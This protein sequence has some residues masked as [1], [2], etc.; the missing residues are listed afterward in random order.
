MKKLV[1]FW[2]V[3]VTSVCFLPYIQLID[4]F[5]F[6]KILLIKSRYLIPPPLICCDPL[7]ST[8]Q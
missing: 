1:I 7:F 6:D 5:V 3:R 4:K 2:V 8:T